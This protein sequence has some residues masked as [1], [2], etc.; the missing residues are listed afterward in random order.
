MNRHTALLHTTA[1]QFRNLTDVVVDKYGSRVNSLRIV[2]DDQIIQICILYWCLTAVVTLHKLSLNT[3][4]T[5]M[6]NPQKKRQFEI[7]F[8]G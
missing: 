8:F 3:G 1:V 7:L 5:Y 4:K 6:T 2:S